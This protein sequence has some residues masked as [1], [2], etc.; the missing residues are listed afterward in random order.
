MMT[1]HERKLGWC[2]SMHGRLMAAALAVLIG[3]MPDTTAAQLRTP[4]P[5]IVA[6]QRPKLVIESAF[7]GYAAAHFAF[8]ADGTLLLTAGG[9]DFAVSV[10][11]VST[12]R[13][14]RVL[15][16]DT[17]IEG[18]S[19]TS[20][21][22]LALTR[23]KGGTSTLWDVALGTIVR[24]LDGESEASWLAPNGRA[25]AVATGSTVTLLGVRDSARLRELRLP[26]PVHA[27]SYLASENS[28]LVI[29]GDG[30]FALWNTTSSAPSIL[31]EVTTQIRDAVMSSDGSILTRDLDGGASVWD[32]RCS[33]VRQWSPLARTLALASRGD[34]TI[35]V[36][37]DG[38]TS[39]R[40]QDGSVRRYFRPLAT[41]AAAFAPF[42][43]TAI[44]VGE[45]EMV[46]FDLDTGE[47]VHH[48]ERRV[49]NL[50]STA[51]SSD[52]RFLA[53]AS[54]NGFVN[55]WDLRTGRQVAHFQ[56]WDG[57]VDG[58][59]FGATADE[60]FTVAGSYMR[61]WR[62][63][64]GSVGEIV[65]HRT[66]LPGEARSVS[67]SRTGDQILLQTRWG[68]G[69]VIDVDNFGNFINSR[70][71][72][73]GKSTHASRFSPG[74]GL[75]AT[76]FNLS[77]IAIWDTRSGAKLSEFGDQS[78]DL[79]RAL[80]LS[81]DGQRLLTGSYDK[82]ATV[83]NAV[84]GVPIAKLTGHESPVIAV[85]L[86]ASG[87]RAV[88]GSGFMPGDGD[89]SVRLWD[90]DSGQ[91]L[92]VFRGH[93][94]GVTS[95]G[96]VSESE[97][98]VFSASSDGTVRFWSVGA[99]D[100]DF[101]LIS[102]ASGNWV[103][104]APDGRFDTGDFDDL[105]GM[106]WIRD[107]AAFA[108]LS[109]D[110]FSREYYQPG[111]AARAG[112]DRRLR[113]LARE[114]S[115]ARDSPTVR[116][117]GIASSPSGL[118]TVPLLVNAP[119]GAEVVLLR[120]DR[121]VAR[122]ALSSG[123]R[124]TRK[125]SFDRIALPHR[126]TVTFKSYAFG[127]DGIKSETAYRTLSLVARMPAPKPRAFIVAIGVSAYESRTMN[128]AHSAD[129]AR[130][131]A[132]TL[133]TWFETSGRYG[134]VYAKVLISE[135]AKTATN[136]LPATKRE[137]HDAIA[138][139]SRSSGAPGPDDLV[140]VYFSGHGYADET[141]KYFL[142]PS[143][144]G[145][146]SNASARTLKRSISTDE[147]ARWLGPIDAGA[148]ALILDSCY[149][150]SAFSQSG[151]RPAPLGNR[152]LGQLAYDKGIWIMA[153]SQADSVALESAKLGHSLL[154]YS[155]LNDAP[156]AAA[157]SDH[158]IMDM[159]WKALMRV[160]TERV[161][162]LY[163]EISRD[164]TAR[165]SSKKV[166]ETELR[167]QLQTPVVFDF[168]DD[169][170]R[171][172]A[173]P[174]FKSNYETAG[175]EAETQAQQKL[176]EGDLAAADA[177]LRRALQ[178]FQ[179]AARPGPHGDA[180]M[181]LAKVLARMGRKAEAMTSYE[182]ALVDFQETRDRAKELDVHRAIGLELSADESAR[183]IEELTAARDLAVTIGHSARL[184]DI[185]ADLS[186]IY[187]VLGEVGIATALC[188]RSR[189]TT[190]QLGSLEADVAGKSSCSVP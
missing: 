31:C 41:K 72:G 54:T 73:E 113:A 30:F 36:E 39:L 112:T 5:T 117:A 145:T 93:T 17:F 181:A 1:N 49:A 158:A 62:L 160:A 105:E 146:S 118:V 82:T 166:I 128:L 137:I 12:G 18:L 67:V 170:D 134:E 66:E 46:A 175:V 110:T 149:S 156:S 183:A 50:T 20:N 126:D 87:H 163:Q 13:Q 58:L 27:V 177:D 106:H 65:F 141:G 174:G 135:E 186:N 19:L 173:I 42:G 97:D 71:I 8:A 90:A 45:N 6:K 162:E 64:G 99:R 102:F 24:V 61:Q 182:Q 81:T 44:G 150:G 98:R 51:L 80:A 172:V 138:A 124:T 57:I 40:L 142:L 28:T 157:S 15:Q 77:R 26:A 129:D 78:E 143:D 3:C 70:Q 152:G 48:F 169:S 132:K 148:I 133:S 88:T 14:L 109:V 86:S 103:A 187:R 184:A 83:W 55:I 84:N 144:I 168:T 100:E 38:T 60:I 33:R 155:I 91:Q 190:R 180:S 101:R 140:I 120:D 104:A 127:P 92:A 188:E 11:D 47:V 59:A 167:N 21:G 107:G 178:M 89:A 131:I 122:T 159:T 161:P 121:V 85:A 151:F 94:S 95:V 154:T 43:R 23:T 108:P 52:G 171:Y 76:N 136:A 10:W 119:E 116:I 69:V 9:P 111:L 16:H 2:S 164:D 165:I 63:D 147:L 189:A 125:V 153:A 22:D 74:G 32:R 79:V 68:G 7:T 53:A 75:I 35:G 34:A 96:F 179:A 4:Q 29:G 25:V 176:A 139:L 130:A 123:D 185:L 114:P 56:A 115:V 37:A